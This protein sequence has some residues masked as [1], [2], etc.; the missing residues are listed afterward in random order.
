MPPKRRHQSDELVSKCQ[1]TG[2]EKT[3][4]QKQFDLPSEAQ[5]NNMLAMKS[6]P[7]SH[8]SRL[9]TDMF[10]YY[11]T[12]LY[13]RSQPTVRL[14][15]NAVSFCTNDALT[16][17]SVEFLALRG[18][19]LHFLIKHQQKATADSGEPYTYFTVAKMTPDGCVSLLPL[20]FPA[21]AT[22][23]LFH[24]NYSCF[25]SDINETEIRYLV[26]TLIGDLHSFTSTGV[27]SIVVDK[28]QLE[29]I[30][31][32]FLFGTLFHSSQPLERY[33][34]E[35]QI[36]NGTYK[37]RYCITSFCAQGPICINTETIREFDRPVVTPNGTQIVVFQ[38]RPPTI[39][40]M[41][42]DKDAT[43]QLLCSLDIPVN[44]YTPHL[45]STASFRPYCIASVFFEVTGS[46]RAIIIQ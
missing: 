35:Q 25:I 4:T 37:N 40:I 8:M 43:P 26:L 45:N 24:D 14:T 9:P 39:H 32:T 29:H 7:S 17:L 31:R 18:D 5:W 30:R 22:R 23:S 16:F 27:H 1:A 36:S 3:G 46:I 15:N 19:T 41:D 42:L 12:E 21:S 6:D 11:F 34:A 2:I 33:H 20:E 28:G 38:Y 13:A 10:R 44:P